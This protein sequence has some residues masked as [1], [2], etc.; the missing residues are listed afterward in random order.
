M[1]QCDNQFSGYIIAS[2][3]NALFFKD[4][5]WE[6]AAWVPKSQCFIWPQLETISE[7]VMTVSDWLCNK[8][9]WEEPK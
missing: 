6:E 2:T 4:H 7:T 8:N 1:R 5:F 9:G 3:S